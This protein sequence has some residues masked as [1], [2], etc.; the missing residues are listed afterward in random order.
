MSTWPTPAI[1]AFCCCAPAT[2][3]FTITFV[4]FGL[5]LM[6]VFKS[7]IYAF[8]Q[9]LF[10]G[11]STPTNTGNQVAFIQ[12]PELGLKSFIIGVIIIWTIAYCVYFTIRKII[13]EIRNKYKKALEEEQDFLA[14]CYVKMND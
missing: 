13:E 5:F 2:F 4:S 12:H 8:I 11:Q 14:N 10:Y 6:Y 7:E 9:G 3:V 1:D